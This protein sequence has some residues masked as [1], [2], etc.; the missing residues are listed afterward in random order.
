M[1]LCPVFLTLQACQLM[2]G[3]IARGIDL[4][5]RDEPYLHVAAERNFVYA[6][7]TLMDNDVSAEMIDEEN[8]LP[9]IIA[10]NAGHDEM[11]AVILRKM[12]KK[13]YKN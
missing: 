4:G 12:P 2:D 10:L 1:S 8:R 9:V 13:R 5:C 6:A 3:L 7:R 11:A